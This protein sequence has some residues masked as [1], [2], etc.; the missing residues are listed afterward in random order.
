MKILLLKTPGPSPINHIW[1]SLRAILGSDNFI[2]YPY[3]PF[4]HCKR[5]DNRLVAINAKGSIVAY[6][7]HGGLMR[8][9]YSS[10][11][12]PR[13]WCVESDRDQVQRDFDLQEFDLILIDN[14]FDDFG[15]TSKAIEEILRRSIGRIPIVVADR[16]DD[17]LLRALYLVKGVILLKR[18]ILRNPLD[19]IKMPH[20][21]KAILSFRSPIIRYN[22]SLAFRSWVHTSLGIWQINGVIPS[23]LARIVGV[24]FDNPWLRSFNLSFWDH[25]CLSKEKEKDYDVSFIA[26]LT[27][28]LRRSTYEA[29]MRL[30][31]KRDLKIFVHLGRDPSKLNIPYSTYVDII[32]RSK[33]SV[34]APGAG[35]DTYRYW[36]IPCL[37]SALASW[38]PWIRIDNNFVNRESAIFFRDVNE[39]I[40][41][42]LWALKTGAWEDIARKGREWFLKHHT[43]LQRA[44]ALLRIAEEIY[45]SS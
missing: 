29:L 17:P 39:M 41:K 37:G 26:N 21:A 6:E 8:S 28:P 43:P 5:I 38:E 44:R 12:F 16:Y 35:F 13:A 4:L 3:D 14:P 24:A 32:S 18:E 40:S 27:N 36:E 30:S 33:I 31:K 15:R 11:I 9:R 22:L 45:R 42:I 25:G 10:H 2:E 34:S 7:V 19:L 20:L 23:K 1:G